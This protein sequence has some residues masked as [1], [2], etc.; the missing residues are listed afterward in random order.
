MKTVSSVEHKTWT[1][2]SEIHGQSEASNFNAE[3]N[4]MLFILFKVDSKLA[5]SLLPL[6]VTFI[7]R[8]SKNFKLF[9]VF[10]SIS[11]LV[12]LLNNTARRQDL[13]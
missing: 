6:V 12:I 2:L 11:S 1:P 9:R 7:V 10:I 8:L 13:E 3:T 4:L 5:M